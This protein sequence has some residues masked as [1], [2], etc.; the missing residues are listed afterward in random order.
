MPRSLEITRVFLGWDEPLLPRASDWLLGRSAS[1]SGPADL[2]RL[3]VITPGRRAGRRLLEHL[4]ASSTGGGL[5]PPVIA[6]PGALAELLFVPR[7]PLAGALESRLLRAETLRRANREMVE[8]ILSEPPGPDDL[9]GWLELAAELERVEEELALGGLDVDAARRRL[10]ATAVA[11]GVEASE[12]AR[13]EALETISRMTG[14]RLSEGGREG[15][16]AFRLRAAAGG[17]ERSGVELDGVVL[18]GMAE[19]PRLFRGLLESADLP[20]TALVMAPEREAEAFGPWGTP[21]SDVW[22]DRSVEL[23][24]GAVVVADRPADQTAIAVERA[25]AW[26]AGAG[27]AGHEPISIGVADPRMAPTLVDQ[28]SRAGIRAHA[29]HT[30]SLASS[31]PATLLASLSR[32][33]AGRRLT[34]LIALLRLPPVE[35]WVGRR[36][37]EA[38]PELVAADRAVGGL[39]C[40][41]AEG[42]WLAALDRFA[43]ECSADRVDR[44][45]GGAR[46]GRELVRRIDSAVLALLAPESGAAGGECAAG[47]SEESLRGRGHPGRWAGRV[48][49]VLST[50]FAD[51]PSTGAD[52]STGVGPPVAHRTPVHETTF[53]AL[54]ALGDLLREAH[55]I[56]E[57]RAPACS[58]E[59]LVA[60]LLRSLGEGAAASEGEGDEQV[61]VLGWLELG[62]DDAPDLVVIGLNEGIVPA[63]IPAEPFLSEGVRRSLGLLDD[64]RRLTRDLYLLTSLIRSRPRLTLV[65]GRRTAEGEPLAP[66]RL[67]L[68]RPPD[69]LARTVVAFFE[70]APRAGVAATLAEWPAASAFSIPRPECEDS[71]LS[72][73]Q[74]SGLSVTA[75][76]DYLACPYRFYL[77]H[78]LGLEAVG[79]P[80]RE[81]DA[82]SFGRL[83]HE[84]LRRFGLGPAADSADADTITTTLLDELDRVARE[85]LG[86]S[87]VAAA[88][89][90]VA[91]L[92][93]RLEVFA[94]WQADQRRRGWRIERVEL[95]L[96][97]LLEVDGEPFVMRGQLDRVDLHD[98][99]RWRI[100]DFK[101][102][103][104]PRSPEQSHR[105]GPAADK[106]WTDLQLPLYRR[107]ALD[108]D[109]APFREPAGAGRSGCWREIAAAGPL[110]AF[111]SLSKKL[112]AD[113]YAE[114]QWS[115]QELEQAEAR[116]R[117]VVRA[118]RA[119]IF[120]P[121]SEPPAWDDG[122]GW[123]AGDTLADRGRL[124]AES[125]R[126]LA[127]SGGR[128]S[129]AE[130]LGGRRAEAEG[131]GPGRGE[132][133]P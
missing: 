54:A 78:V 81:L 44:P 17:A 5:I 101:T 97:S 30:R 83:A 73:R 117:D 50:L 95:R 74:L 112:S 75:F 125:G 98:D 11:A 80:A 120:W 7:G 106:Q 132:Q 103:D 37:A 133:G 66:S 71:D 56:P 18:V 121:P 26:G 47:A 61:E 52:P 92:R 32:Y 40:A 94:V 90:Q 107:L 58:L 46:E 48:A 65:S 85:L 84:V 33:L 14:T 19:L 1:R 119:G 131:K 91:Q 114:A 100:L 16:Q 118:I 43:A 87:P 59:E 127:A 115:E 8:R 51:D 124:V 41:I 111:Y 3:L 28:L 88:R 29:P 86:S 22:P 57:E 45:L 93:R 63:A 96:E 110:L 68:A 15:A 79:E 102:A 42:R 113:G 49:A 31:L 2:E 10:E 55:S 82:A 34:D 9:T 25:L 69:E 122:Y 12:D 4:L 123:I 70:S 104:S 72:S 38:A 105:R 126:L 62:L 108:A 130:A 24:P 13:W 109:V 116:A 23:G 60:L 27:D 36:L 128:S 76:R 6:T 99:G 77:R 20:V 35:R 129:S 64:R 67:L 53:E 21:R 89:V 39:G